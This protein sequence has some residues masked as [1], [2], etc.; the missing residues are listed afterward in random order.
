M[1]FGVTYFVKGGSFVFKLI[2]QFLD[3]LANTENFKGLY[4]R[5]TYVRVSL[6]MGQT[7]FKHVGQTLFH[8]ERADPI[9]KNYS[10]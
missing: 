5:R 9:K 6:G 8:V 7:R 1:E 2:Q 4:G 3:P 10:G